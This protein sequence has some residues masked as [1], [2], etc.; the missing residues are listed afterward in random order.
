MNALHIKLNSASIKFMFSHCTNTHSEG[1]YVSSCGSLY[2]TVSIAEV[3]SV[4]WAHEWMKACELRRSAKS[5]KNLQYWCMIFYL[6]DGDMLTVRQLTT[7]KPSLPSLKIS[8]FVLGTQTQCLVKLRRARTSERTKVASFTDNL[9]RGHPTVTAVRLPCVLR[10]A[11]V[12]SCLRRQSSA[13]AL[14]VRPARFLENH[15]CPYWLQT[16]SAP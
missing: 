5:Y 3:T 9:K 8:T 10:L 7:L 16:A 13:G 1:K 14:V 15:W 4:I 6:I 12:R 2:R 11:S